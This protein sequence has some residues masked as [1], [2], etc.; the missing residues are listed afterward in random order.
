[1]RSTEGVVVVVMQRARSMIATTRDEK[2][3]FYLSAGVQMG[4]LQ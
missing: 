4:P 3:G 2:R 1:M